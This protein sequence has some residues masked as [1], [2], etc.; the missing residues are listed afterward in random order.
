M[1]LPSIANIIQNRWDILQ[2]NP[3]LTYT[4]PD[5][6]MLT[7]RRSK[8]IKDMIGSNN[9]LH[10]RIVKTTPNTKTIQLCQ[11]CNHINSLC[12]KFLYSTKTFTSHIT[13]KAYDIYHKT[14]SKSKNVIYLLECT[15][16]SMQYV[17]KSESPFDLRLNNFKHRRKPYNSTKK[18]QYY[19]DIQKAFFVRHSSEYKT[20][21]SDRK[22][23][24]NVYPDA[25]TLDRMRLIDPKSGQLGPIHH[26]L[27]EEP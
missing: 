10:N 27:L 20:S 26:C 7:F 9:I 25:V 17:S 11:P 15:L 2:L 8:N 16:C 12:C 4:F 5:T 18:R 22:V 21:D 6:A 23:N 3:N 19:F 24:R 13:N 14:N 1:T